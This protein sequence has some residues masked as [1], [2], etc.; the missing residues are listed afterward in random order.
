VWR[1]VW[2]RSQTTHPRPYTVLLGFSLFLAACEIEQIEIPRPD[3]HVAMHA[4]LSA[5]APSQVVLLERTR[6]GSIYVLAPP[7][8][9]EDPVVTDEGIAETRAT[10]SMTTPDGQTLFAREDAANNVS[11][12]GGGIYRF[13]VPGNS[14]QRGGTYRLSVL[15][16]KGE[17]LSAET[18]VP[19]G[20]AAAVAEQIVFDRAGDAVTVEW[21]AAT[22]A[23]SYFVRFET[24][25]GPRSFFTDSTHV[26]LS[27]DLRN[28][29]V[30]G[31]PRVFFPGFQQV[32]TVSAVD[33]NYYDWFRTHNNALTGTG[34]INRVSGGFGVFGSL[35][36]L[37][38]Q[39][40]H[41]VA[42]QT[43][44]VTGTFEFVGTALQRSVARY[45][46]LELYVESR[47]ARADQEDALSGRS[48]R[49]LNFGEVVCS[50]CGVLGSARGSH[51]EIALLDSWYARDTADVFTGEI[52]GDTIV[53]SFRGLGGPVRF[54]RKP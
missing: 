43:E 45:T 24:P 19:E 35:V 3:S 42:P 27:G 15:T 17:A 21:P 26:R 46:G 6:N 18:S 41:V 32:V 50:V 38:F 53:G 37:R 8:D 5:S 31:L 52:H 39:D 33:S 25:F 14:L 49:Q 1:E 36:R 9:L 13:L 48:Q 34:L 20:A 22:G 44:P 2:G 51:I 28:I 12:K 4:V 11:G 47:A 16:T 10:I 30:A 54:A 29:E 40:I 23:R 7:F